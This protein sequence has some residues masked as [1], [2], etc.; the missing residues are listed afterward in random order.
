MQPE[1]LE[2]VHKSLEQAKAE[3]R[4]EIRALKG[5]VRLVNERFVSG[6]A[7]LNR[8]MDEGFDG[9]RAQLDVMQAQLA[10]VVRRLSPG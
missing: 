3:L 2:D 10:E 7:E 4:D 8:R 1:T 9:M 5:D 6:M